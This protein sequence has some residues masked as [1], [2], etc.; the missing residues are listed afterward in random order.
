MA[1]HICQRKTNAKLKLNL[2]HLK[3]DH[4]GCEGRLKQF[5]NH[6]HFLKENSNLVKKLV[7]RTKLQH[8]SFCNLIL[9]KN[10]LTVARVCQHK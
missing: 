9:S 2:S 1:S 5:R 7:Q 4:V 8:K 6:I 3:Q 10:D